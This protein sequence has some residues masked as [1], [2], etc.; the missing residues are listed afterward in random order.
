MEMQGPDGGATGLRVLHAT[1]PGRLRVKVPGLKHEPA[2]KLQLERRLARCPGVFSAEASSST[3]NLLVLF[4]PQLANEEIVARL[5]ALL[6]PVPAEDEEPPVP[7]HCLPAEAIIERLGSDVLEGLSAAESDLRLRRFGANTLPRNQRR[8]RLQILV[9]QFT[10]L[11]VLL[12]GASAVLAVCTGGLV[13]AVV[14][15]AVVAL[16]GTIGYLTETRAE[17]AIGSLLV[18]EH[19]RTTI[20]RAGR[21]VEI[22]ATSLVPGDIIDLTAG[23]LVCG[24]ARLLVSR[25]LSMDESILTGE[26]LPAEKDAAA[27]CAADA[28]LA[29][30]G[31]MLFAGTRASSGW[32]RAVVVATDADTEVG[33][34]QQL[35]G[36]VEPPQ[37]PL[38][39]Q[40][41]ELSRRLVALCLAISAVTFLIGWWRGIPALTMLRGAVALAVAALPEGLPTIATTALAIGV[42]RLRRQGVLV[43]HLGTVEALGAVDTVLFDK[44]GTLTLNRMSVEAIAAPEDGAAGAGTTRLLEIASLCNDAELGGGQANGSPTEL[45]LLRAAARAGI[46]LSALLRRHPRLDERGRTARQ[47]SMATLHAAGDGRLLA[48]KGSPMEVLDLCDRVSTANGP[49]RLDDAWRARIAGANA[50]MAIK[51]LRIL[52]VAEKRTDGR[53]VEEAAETD[54]LWLGLTGLADPIR[55][56]MGEVVAQLHRAGLGTLM[57]TGDQPATA[58][59]IARQ[60]G[61]ANGDGRVRVADAQTLAACGDIAQAATSTDAFA[62]IAPADKLV[63]VRGLQRN[64]RV[65][66]MLGD[67]I[68]DGPALKAADVGL[69][70]AGAGTDMAKELADAALLGD[71]PR[72]LVAAIGQGRGMRRSVKTSLR[73]LLATNLSEI[74][75]VVA[76]TILGLEQPLRPL[77]LLWINLVSDVLPGLALATEPSTEETLAQ[78]PEKTSE[79]I[80]SGVD[81]T[82]LGEQAGVMGAG[83]LASYAWGQRSGVGSTM[84]THSLVVSQMLHAFSARSTRHGLFGQSNPRRNRPLDLAV[85]GILAAQLLVGAFPLSRRLLGLDSIDLGQSLVAMAAGVGPYLLNEARKAQAG[86]RSAPPEATGRSSPLPAQPRR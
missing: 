23:D 57:I 18:Q 79:P 61:I 42:G 5:S 10:T 63:I 55:Q 31:N 35:L 41:G 60:V 3:G 16:N 85:A 86:V 29:D 7:W 48:V 40:L 51:G 22:E 56:N 64:R 38:Q 54:L 34:I 74:L 30:R 71:D 27:A 13:D 43:R 8:S 69:T 84:A 49:A 45:A 68:N 58:E 62:R 53:T 12:L 26:S 37:T 50:A 9:G 32:A 21:L 17:R 73:F 76:A 25:N 75:L 33:R 83:A 6:E 20:M 15:G 4:D 66:A 46:D 78:P 82:R 36:E 52:G 47:Q 14:I 2:R 1:V 24:D 72:G 39:R 59:A 80:L 11:P 77:Q 28:A 19:N 81:F 44:T 70:F 65:V 67:G